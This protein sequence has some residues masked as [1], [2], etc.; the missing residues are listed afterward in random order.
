MSKTRGILLC[1]W[2]R[3][4]YGYA[5]FNLAASIRSLSPNLPIT[6]ICDNVA[7][8]QLPDQY[9]SV[10]DSIQYLD[11]PVSDPGI[12]KVSI[13]DKLPYDYTLFLDV[14]A[15]AIN[16]PESLIERCIK[17][18]ESDGRFF[19][20]HVHAWYDSHSPE[21]LPLMYWAN[22]STIWNKY[23]FTQ[24][25]LPAT[26][27]S[28]QFIAKCETA[29]KWFSELKQLMVS[30]PIPI[31][32]LKNKWGGTQP[33]ELYLNIQIARTGIK[34]DLNDAMWF[35]D[36]SN[37]SPYELKVKGYTF[38]S[39]FGVLQR[40]KAH[41]R[42]YYDR[43]PVRFLRQLGFD[44]HLYKSHTVFDS[45][46]AGNKVQSIKRINPV[47]PSQVF[48]PVRSGYMIDGERI[49][50]DGWGKPAFE[51]GDLIQPEQVPSGLKGTVNLYLCNLYET[52]PDNRKAE[53]MECHRINCE[54]P[55][56][57]KIYNFGNVPYDHPKV[58]NIPVDTRPTYQDLIDKAN[59]TDS[60]YHVLTNSD[61]YYDN[62]LNWLE[63]IDFDNLM[64]ALC[65]WNIIG[66]QV[67]FE[68]YKWSQGTW[69]FKG[70]INAT[71][72]NYE[73]GIPGC[74]NAFALDVNKQG[75]SV[76]NPSVDIRAYHLH[77]SNFR[78][79]T[80]ADR[81]HGNG[82][83]EVKVC[84]VNSVLRKTLLIN[85][86][87]AVGDIVRCLPIAKY[88]ADQGYRVDWLCPRR[89]H[90]L[91]QY[92]DYVKP[93][94]SN[95]ASYSKT[96][97]LSFGINQHSDV[98]KKWIAER[99]NLHSF[100]T[101]KFQLAEVPFS[102]KLIYSRNEDRENQLYKDL[103]CD[104]M[105]RFALCHLDS[106]YGDPAVCSTDLPRIDFKPVG[107]YTIFDWR[108]VIEAASE[109]HCIDSSLAN[110]VDC[111]TVLGSLHYYITSKVPNQWDRTRLEKNW[112]VINQLE[113]E[114][115]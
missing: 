68:A 78:T 32:Q 7:L 52:L 40:I 25:K 47:Q 22:K 110:F 2:G 107:D 24:E 80:Q 77:A 54:N 88:Y 44:N 55:L 56:I 101:Y 94:L 9:K 3:V 74:E 103:G 97:D 6:L 92:V 104:K 45:K 89:F 42:T 106:N 109:I 90:S 61:L 21:D 37:H 31:D 93:V 62:T 86:P 41:F 51:T 72:C 10:F 96:I 43:E 111:L 5:A 20:T 29:D 76:K 57:T 75:Y 105:D 50:A 113:Y 79:Y 85:Q 81:I 11:S 4:N 100:L 83:L 60:D 67:K 84:S 23:G 26:Q 71:G 19:R 58:V 39:Y 36:N 15:L 69:I 28:I 66:N 115:S 18:Y 91:F 30:N 13:Y 87:G 63:Y 108:K 12:F 82:Y 34:P 53:L 16:S 38:L 98:H 1:S 49:K 14:D 48:A 70:K 27:S 35:C 46:H 95:I 112:E 114:H 102:N 73:L 99:V 17:D 8:S 59:E 65:R 33:D 64:L